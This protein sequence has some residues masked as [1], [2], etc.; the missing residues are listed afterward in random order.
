V[1]LLL[2]TLFK[3][4]LEESPPPPPTFTRLVDRG[5]PSSA[6]CAYCF[7]ILCNHKL[8]ASPPAFAH[9]VDGGWPSVA[10]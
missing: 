10:L 3:Q 5:L 4:E 7:L 1:G 9:L 6:W 2:L 8:K